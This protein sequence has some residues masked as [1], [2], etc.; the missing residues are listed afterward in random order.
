MSNFELISYEEYPHDM[1]TKAVAMVRIENRYVVN[2]CLKVSKSGGHFWAPAT[3]GVTQNGEKKYIQAFFCDSMSEQKMLEKFIKDNA[4]PE[5]PPHG[6]SQAP[7]AIPSAAV[8][9]S[10][11][12]F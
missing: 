6:V 5:T 2:Y 1:Y 9:D 8:P 11:I 10:E 4:N 12:P 3:I 7:K